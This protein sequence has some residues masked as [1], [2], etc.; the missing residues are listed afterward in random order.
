MDNRNIKELSE[1]RCAWDEFINTGQVNNYSVKSKILESWKRCRNAGVDPYGGICSNLL[2]SRQLYRLLT[3]NKELINVARP[4]MY[5]LYKFLQ[6]SGCIVMLT[7]AEGYILEIF[8]DDNIM[9]NAAALNFITGGCWQEETVG[10]NS[11]GVVVKTKEPIQVT[12]AEHFCVK[13]HGWTCS[14]A[15]IFDNS[16]N[17]I[18]IFNVSGE[19]SETHAH[20][21]GMVVAAVAAIEQEITLRRRNQQ[22]LLMNQRL[23][24]IFTN[25]SEAV[26]FM[27]KNGIVKEMNPAAKNLLGD[28]TNNLVEDLV[29]RRN[30][31]RNSILSKK[32]L[33]F[34]I[35]N[36]IELLLKGKTCPVN[37][38]VSG[39]PINDE[40]G[41]I[42]GT[43]M[44][45]KPMESVQTLVKRY[46][47]G[48]ASFH[49]SD[50]VG[51]SEK[52][53][54][55]IR[56]A[57]LAA[58]NN[59]TI[60]LQGES[61]TGKEI[62]AQSIHN[63]SSRYKGPF[64]AVNCG[65]IPRELIGSELFGYSEGAFTGAKRGGRSGKFELANG[66][67]LF[68]DE[69]GDMPLEQQVTLLRVL[70]ERRLIRIGD[71]KEIPVD[72]RV[73]CAT[74][75]D[76]LKEIERFNF[77]QDLFY[78]INVFNITI[79][80][81]RDHLED[82]PLLFDN[83]AEQLSKRN[84][85]EVI[86][87]NSKVYDYLLRYNWPGNVRELQN[88]VER[89]V[90]MAGGGQLMVEHIPEEIMIGLKDGR[91]HNHSIEQE[92]VTVDGVR[93]EKA[94]EECE[95][96][97]KLLIKNGG[98]VTKVAQEIGLSRNTLYKKLR[99]YNIKT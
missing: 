16:D 85:Y 52:M 22:L 13:S 27:D 64:V 69:I 60:L 31:R 66:G 43:V 56:I 44:I 9:E 98:N 81:L 91:V 40:S 95:Q 57:S 2:E 29:I 71:E 26:I 7:D 12:G 19:S 94:K 75:K 90:T 48:L 55:A 14:A 89:M 10:T 74:N 30:I 97:Q 65:A 18:G 82:M 23:T 28:F 73:I 88:I 49:F 68:L 33:L 24:N 37:C 54:E 17:M 35:F 92:K 36:D 63:A 72:V 86:S 25:I 62:F 59:G 38:L 39:S 1:A 45:I 5:K 61:G 79:P 41:S 50:I 15:P 42:N 8:G 58:D 80:P 20:T 21:L 84:N 83:F 51:K 67:T 53:K 11:M 6:G 3:E 87:V 93:Q 70:Q 46:S 77:R 34:T 96:I 78:R 4:F 32:N 99:K 76:L 47:S